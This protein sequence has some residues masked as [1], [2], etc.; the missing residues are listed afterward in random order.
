MAIDFVRFYLVANALLALAALM[1]LL[2]RATSARSRRP[3][4]CRTQLRLAYGLIGAAII[5]PWLAVPSGGVELMPA[6]TQVWAAPSMHAVTVAAST[7]DGAISA[8]DS[9]A[10]FPLERLAQALGIICLAGLALAAGRVFAGAWSVRQVLRRAHLIRRSGSLRIVSS[11]EADVPFSCWI[12]GACYIFV[13]STLILQPRDFAIALRHEAQ[14]HRQGDTR[15]VYVLELLRGV[16]FLNPLMPVLL[17]QVRGL[18]EFACDEALVRRVEPREYCECLIRVARNAMRA[19]H[20]AA[21]LHMAGAEGD[22]MLARRIAAVL[23]EPGGR[24]GRWKSAMLNGLAIVALV[25][26]GIGLSSSVQDR[27]VSL[28]EAL[29]LAAVARTNSA[30]PIVVNEQVLTELNRFLGTPDGRAFLRDGLKR[31]SDHEGLISARLAEHGLPQELLAVPLVE[32]GYRNLAQSANPRHGAGIWMF[33]KPTARR[34]GLMVE[35]DH[36]ERLNVASETD[37]AMRMLS[38][39]HAEFGDWSFALL[40]YNTGSERVHR[41]VRDRGVADAFRAA[42]QGYENDPGYLARVTAAVIVMKN[43]QRLRLAAAP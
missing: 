28:S 2:V 27:R 7:L 21:C 41:A 6:M 37:A 1:L 5:G 22:S 9:Q 34:F 4:S 12:P 3:M 8:G 18:Q 16:F 42:E 26:T 30:F 29:E 39:L 35:T 15:F 14:H 19:P 40:A 33:I 25:G 31:M 23:K 17:K 24:L 43:T 11:D 20:S 13:P 36:D 32:S 10:S 38:G